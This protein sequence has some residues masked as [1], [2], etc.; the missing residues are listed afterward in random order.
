MRSAMLGWFVTI[1]KCGHCPRRGAGTDRFKRLPR[2]NQR[3]AAVE[4]IPV[5]QSGNGNIYKVSIG[6]LYLPAR[7][8]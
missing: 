1:G 7:I 6:E 4:V 2:I 3:A 5:Q 8:G